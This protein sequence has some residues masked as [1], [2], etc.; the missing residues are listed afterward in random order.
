VVVVRV[1]LLVARGR[2]ASRV[3]VAAGYAVAS[4]GIEIAVELTRA[5]AIVELAAGVCAA[6]AGSGRIGA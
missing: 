2:V 1:R 5:L 4:D 3:A 6:G